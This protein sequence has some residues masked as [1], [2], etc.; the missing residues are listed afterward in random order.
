MKHAVRCLDCLS[1]G[2]GRLSDV[3]SWPYSSRAALMQPSATPAPCRYD[4]PLVIPRVLPSHLDN[5]SRRCRARL[6]RLTLAFRVGRA[7]RGPACHRPRP[8]Y[9]PHPEAVD[10]LPGPGCPAIRLQ[11]DATPRA[12]AWGFAG[13][14]SAGR[15]PPGL[16]PLVVKTISLLRAGEDQPHTGPIDDNSIPVLPSRS[17]QRLDGPQH[18]EPAVLPVAFNRSPT[19]IDPHRRSEPG[20]FHPLGAL[21]NRASAAPPIVVTHGHVIIFP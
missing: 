2:R 8:V 5:G 11:D 10:P 3:E 17:S 14:L 19:T 9:H 16:P 18:P 13:P 7:R 6:T 15:L 12:G 4:P 21:H 1:L 20:R